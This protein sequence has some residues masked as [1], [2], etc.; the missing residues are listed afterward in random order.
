MA[1]CDLQNL[2]LYSISI[3]NFAGGSPEK[4]QNAMICRLYSCF[5]LQAIARHSSAASRMNVRCF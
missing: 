3:L 1:F 2:M 4:A 5:N